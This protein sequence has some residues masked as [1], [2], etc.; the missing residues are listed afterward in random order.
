MRAR[1]GTSPGA[2]GARLRS[3]RWSELS[4]RPAGRRTVWRRPAAQAPG[5]GQ[6]E[7]H[8][9]VAEAGGAPAESESS[10]GRAHAVGGCP[11]WAGLG[12]RAGV[13][14]LVGCRGPGQWTPGE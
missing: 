9:Q 1:P 13:E 11:G 7:G 4:P 5:H 12:R 10:L 3:G 14:R 8:G 6:G 2:A